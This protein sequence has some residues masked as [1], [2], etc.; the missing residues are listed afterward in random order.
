MN[1]RVFLFLMLLLI[2]LCG[3]KS[4]P[5]ESE[6]ID[7]NGMI[8]DTGNRPVANYRIYIDGKGECTSDIGGRFVIYGIKKGEHVFSGFGEGYLAIEENITVYDKAQIL[9]IRV[10]SVDSCFRQAFDFMKKGHLEKAE[11]LISSV[12]E[13]DAEN[14]DAL[15]FMKTI[16]ELRRRNEK[17]GK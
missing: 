6:T 5:K 15:Y 16:N 10:P 3:C 11:K 8:Y 9:Y 2:F 14:E 13:S 7:V 1:K 17:N 4:I 12:L